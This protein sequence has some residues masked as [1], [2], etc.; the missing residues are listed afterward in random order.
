MNDLHRAHE[1]MDVNKS[2]TETFQF[3]NHNKSNRRVIFVGG[4]F[5]SHPGCRLSSPL[6][7]RGALTLHISTHTH[8]HTNGQ[9]HFTVQSR[10]TT[11]F[12]LPE[13]NL[14]RYSVRLSLSTVLEERSSNP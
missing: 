9:Y 12:L 14:Q 11:S 8:T 4:W 2:Q 1:L 13:P 5:I 10:R 7:T 6:I 3:T